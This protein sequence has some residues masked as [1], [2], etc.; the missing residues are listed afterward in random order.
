[1]A[2]FKLYNYSF[3]QVKKPIQVSLFE[4]LPIIS[5]DEI[6]AQKQDLFSKILHDENLQFYVGTKTYRHKIPLEY[7]EVYLLKI[8]NNGKIR[9]EVDFQIHKEEHFPSC[10]VIIDN[11][12]DV[13]NI[14]IQEIRSSFTNTDQVARILENTFNDKLKPYRLKLTINAKYSETEF[15]QFAKEHNEEMQMVRFHFLPPNIP[16]YTDILGPVLGL[17]SREMNGALTA[18]FNSDKEQVLTL[19]ENNKL[20]KEWVKL[21]SESGTPTEI[22]LVGSRKIYKVGKGTRIIK[23]LNDNALDVSVDSDGK[24]EIEALIIFMNENKRSNIL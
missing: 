11:R 20:Q 8:A 6:W 16:D 1:M 10:S 17:S 7:N 3:I 5:Q 12:K 19:D 15:W 2:V 22:Q 18:Q 13:Q 21:S 24:Q 14:A 23:E 9:R 4:D